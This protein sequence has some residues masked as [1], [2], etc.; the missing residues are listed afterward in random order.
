MGAAGLAS[1]TTAGIVG[2]STAAG[3][4][5][6]WLQRFWEFLVFEGNFLNLLIDL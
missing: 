6:G 3:G 4:A 2:A 1:S 5:A